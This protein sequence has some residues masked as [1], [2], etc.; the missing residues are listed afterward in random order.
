MVKD[1]KSKYHGP[2][3]YFCGPS[4]SVYWFPLSRKTQDVILRS[5]FKVLKHHRTLAQSLPLLSKLLTN[6]QLVFKLDGSFVLNARREEL[7]QLIKS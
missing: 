5:K 4:N 7:K 3:V 2:C 6:S 1:I